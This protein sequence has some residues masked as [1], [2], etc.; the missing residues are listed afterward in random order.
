[1][2]TCI[3]FL[4]LRDFSSVLSLASALLRDAL[5]KGLGVAALTTHKIFTNIEE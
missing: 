2:L 4:A 1:M 5:E 3:V